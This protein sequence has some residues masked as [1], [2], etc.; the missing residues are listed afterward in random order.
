MG[1]EIMILEILPEGNSFSCGRWPCAR[2]PPPA[3]DNWHEGQYCSA[4]L[5]RHP[6]PVTERCLGSLDNQD[7]GNIC[8]GLGDL[9]KRRRFAIPFA[10]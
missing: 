1:Y 10:E 3:K 7:S 2:P 4:R 5:L 8:L 9:Q 6:T